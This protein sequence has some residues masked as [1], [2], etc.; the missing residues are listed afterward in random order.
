MEGRS[1][2]EYNAYMKA[3]ILGFVQEGLGALLAYM[4]AEDACHTLKEFL[5]ILTPQAEIEIENKR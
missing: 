2:K 3:K 1:E 4:N 5:A